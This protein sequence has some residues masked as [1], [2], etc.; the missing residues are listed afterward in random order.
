MTRRLTRDEA[1]SRIAELEEALE[2]AHG[3]LEDATAVVED[4][5]GI[6]EEPAE[7]SESETEVN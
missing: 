6:E 4:A 3:A 1:L 7:D 2:E 5:L